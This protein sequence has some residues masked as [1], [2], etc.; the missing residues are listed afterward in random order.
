MYASLVLVLCIIV[1]VLFKN[2]HPKLKLPLFLIMATT[3]IGATLTLFGSTIY[4]NTKSES[5]GPVHWHTEVEFWACS[6]ELELRN[7]TGT[8]S[9]KIGTST[10]HEHNDK[11][12]HLEGVVVRK[13]EDASLEK[14][15]RVTGGY[16]TDTSIGVPLNN[17]ESEW[18]TQGEQTDGDPQDLSSAEV[19]KNY[20]KQSDNK[21]IV[22]L[23]NG[24][25]CGSGEAGELQVFVYKF[26][27]TNDTYA[28]EK[29]AKPSSYIMSED[30]SLGPPS[31][32]VIVEFD[33]PKDR[34]DKLCEQYGVRDTERCTS[35]GVKSYD[36]GQCNI[37]EIQPTGGSQ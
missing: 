15:M 10:Y 17:D 28:Q 27:K 11:H 5:K 33:V 32:C 18:Y 6:A 36:P 34:T 13:S 14:F 4:L 25:R 29:L 2:K 19:L 1:A 16:L 20:V 22:E 7:P 8:L 9:N 23:K 35:F 24:Q 30:S 3:L 31:D 12:I 21:S 26:N 37:R